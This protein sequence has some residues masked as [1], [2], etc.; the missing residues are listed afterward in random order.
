MD[1]QQLGE[2]YDIVQVP[3]TVSPFGMMEKIRRA[4]G[5]KGRFEDLTIDESL[6]K[7]VMVGSPLIELIRPR[8][9]PSSFPYT[10]PNLSRSGLRVIG[11]SQ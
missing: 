5:R 7:E 2:G 4:V 3:F 9:I 1:L 8:A 6:W 11:A 10:S